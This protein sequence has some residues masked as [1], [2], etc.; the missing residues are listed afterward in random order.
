MQA[1]LI[2]PTREVTRRGP[3]KEVAARRDRQAFRVNIDHQRFIARL[4]EREAVALKQKVKDPFDFLKLFGF[5]GMQG[6][7]I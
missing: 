7:I 4:A 1:F 3:F 5:Q 6:A 2:G